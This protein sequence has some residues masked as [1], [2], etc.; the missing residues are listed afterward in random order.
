MDL[1]DLGCEDVDWI[2]VT[3]AKDWWWAVVNTVMNVRVS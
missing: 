1:R 2:H 3:E